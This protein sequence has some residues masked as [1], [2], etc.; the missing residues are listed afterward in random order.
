[1]ASTRNQGELVNWTPRSRSRLS[2]RQD[3]IIRSVCRLRESSTSR[4]C[5]DVRSVENRSVANRI[6]SRTIRGSSTND[7]EL[8]LAS[9]GPTS[10][11]FEAFA[12][13]S[14]SS[15]GSWPRPSPPAVGSGVSESSGLRRWRGGRGDRGG[16]IGSRPSWL[17][18][19]GRRSTDCTRGSGEFAS[20]SGSGL[21]VHNELFSRAGFVAG[22]PPSDRR[23]RP[24]IAGMMRP[25]APKL[26]FFHDA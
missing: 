18:R 1:M 24:R 2:S 19:G 25:V 23:G 3:L 20:T 17:P 21:S 9:R 14:V 8:G 10:G 11:S 16:V 26:E 5:V 6:G 4:G 22:W 13:S 15:R 7:V 12:G